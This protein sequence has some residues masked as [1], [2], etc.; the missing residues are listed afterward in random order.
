[1]AGHGASPSGWFG[2]LGWELEAFLVVSHGTSHEARPRGWCPRLVLVRVGP[3]TRPVPA[4]GA[5]SKGQPWGLFPRLACF[6]LPPLGY[7]Q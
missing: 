4:V 2:W 7:V 3:A 6:L 1:M 5:R